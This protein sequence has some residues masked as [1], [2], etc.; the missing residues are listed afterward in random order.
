MEPPLD[1]VIEISRTELAPSVGVTVSATSVIVKVTGVA[2][3]EPAV[4][5]AGSPKSPGSSV[6]PLEPE[7]LTFDTISVSRPA[8]SEPP[9]TDRY[10]YWR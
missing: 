7:M 3:G 10:R 9:S 6:L 5:V 1:A 4:V 2:L 8:D